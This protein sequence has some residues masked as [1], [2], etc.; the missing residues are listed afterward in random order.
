MRKYIAITAAI[1]VVMVL[2]A[3]IFAI[4]NGFSFSASDGG[5]AAER[6]EPAGDDATLNPTAIATSM[7]LAVKT[8]AEQ[9]EITL[10]GISRLPYTLNHSWTDECVL[11]Y[12]LDDVPDGDR[13]YKWV[14][15]GTGPTGTPWIATLTSEKNTVLVLRKFNENK[16]LSNVVEQNDDLAQDNSNSRIEWTPVERAEYVFVMTTY[17]ANTL[18]DFTLTIEDSVPSDQESPLGQRMEGVETVTSP[19]NEETPD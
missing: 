11:P 9:C 4:G 16:E 10:I 14:R 7:P 18:G 13:Y 3:T 5:T 1:A 15:L 2:A 6:T 17:T 12:Q 8:E 19:M